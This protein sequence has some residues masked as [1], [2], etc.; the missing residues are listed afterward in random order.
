[1]IRLNEDIILSRLSFEFVRGNTLKTIIAIRDSK[2]DFKRIILLNN[3]FS[4]DDLY[5]VISTSQ[6]EWYKK[7]WNCIEINYNW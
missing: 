3:D 1:M 4:T 5:Y 6:T 2:S 7:N